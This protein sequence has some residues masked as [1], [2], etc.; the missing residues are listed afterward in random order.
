MEKPSLFPEKVFNQLLHRV[1]NVGEPYEAEYFIVIDLRDNMPQAVDVFND[2]PTST[3]GYSLGSFYPAMTIAAEAAPVAILD[4]E[5]AMWLIGQSAINRTEENIDLVPGDL[6]LQKEQP[7]YQLI[8]VFHPFFHAN[9]TSSD[10]DQ[11]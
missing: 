2:L 11:K 7:V 5:S 1:R 8:P 4:K 9:K 10:A 3:H 6:H